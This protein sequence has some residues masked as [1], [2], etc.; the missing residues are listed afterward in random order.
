M[1]STLIGIL[2]VVIGF[3]GTLRWAEEFA[4]ILRGLI[5]VSL[6]LGGLVG[7]LAGVSSLQARRK[8]D[9]AKK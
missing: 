2:F 3:M 9:N 5:P 7:I 6:I 4:V 8:R 1:I